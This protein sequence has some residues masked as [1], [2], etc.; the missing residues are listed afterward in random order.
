MVLR[1]EPG[2]PD[3][4]MIGDKSGWLV[5]PIKDWAMEECLGGAHDGQPAGHTNGECVWNLPKQR[6]ITDAR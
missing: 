2:M 6:R 4:W 1:H 5:V 3:G